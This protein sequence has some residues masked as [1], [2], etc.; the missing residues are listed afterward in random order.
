MGAFLESVLFA[1]GRIA[2][3]T[4]GR[5]SGVA[6]AGAILVLGVMASPAG[7]VTSAPHARPLAACTDSWKTATSGTWATAAD[8]STGVVPTSSDN[9]CITVPG[10]YS[11][12]ISG[13]ASAG[14]LV[15]GASS[16]KE[17]LK[18]LGNASNNG[19]LTLSTATGSQIKTDGVMKLVSK[20]V[21][22]A[23]Y[24]MITG[25]PSVTLEN[26]GTFETSGGLDAEI[27]LRV[28]ITNDSS[29]I[30]KIKGANT[31]EDG[32]SGATNITNNGTFSVASTGSLKISSGSSFTQSGGTLSNSGSISQTSGT[33]TQSGGTDSGN[34]ISLTTST[35][36]DSSGAGDFD[37]FGADTLS[38]TIPSGQTVDVIGDPASDSTA[39]LGTNVTNNGTFELDSQAASSS[40]YAMLNQSSSDFSFTNDG[41][42]ETVGATVQPDYLRADITNGSS[43][44]LTIDGAD[45]AEDGGSGATTFTNDG[46]FSVG[47]AGGITVSSSSS[48]TQSAGTLTNSGSFKV[49]SGTFT[50]SGGTESGNAIS[51]TTSSLVD[52]AG[53]GDFD[54]FGSDNLSGTLPAGQTVEAIGNTTSNAEVTLG[55][56]ITNNGTFELDSQTASGSGYAM[57]YQSSSDFTFT[58]SATGTFETL[59]ATI[60]PDYLRADITNDSGGTFTIDGAETAEDGGNGATTFTNDG[61]FSVGAGGGL[62]VSSS[63]S[64]TQSAGTLANG[65]SIAVSSGTFTQSGGTD[66]GNA[67]SITTSKLVDSAGAGKFNL[68]GSDTLSGTIP[69]GQTVDV[70]GN[71]TSNAE[72]TLGSNVTNNGTFELDSQTVASS[73]YAMLYQSGSDF[74]FTNA[75]TFETLGATVADDYLRADIT[76]DSGGT[77]TIDGA[78]TAEDGASGA[79]SITNGGTLS[80]GDGDNLA[81]SGSSTFTQSSGGTFSPTVDATTGVWGITGG[82]DSVAGT[83]DVNTVGSP[84]VGNTYNVIGTATL[85][86][87]TFSTVVGSYSVTYTT[88][89]V[90][91]KVT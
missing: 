45:T 23:G 63:S 40:G 51:I 3:K 73:G 29:G 77:L 17:S 87:G 20:N 72:T 39:T 24:A 12:K 31:D 44:T 79:T 42:F 19:V 6:G 76:N 53:G 83:L 80:V 90:T 64:F 35:L 59:G 86:S 13:S 38:G 65:G 16:G 85:V 43:G 5:L 21:S 55:S 32:G 75:G 69:S 26:K 30:V 88:T 68:F 47:S 66:S 22:G 34:A 10:T 33:F 27:Y 58:N 81:I 70:I 91:V 78:E 57:L 9:V 62:T 89:A 1:R 14:T 67:I 4:V 28:N 74:T 52:S 60:E 36:A 82:T 46:T 7:A 2:A 56:N 15:L 8:W 11:V 49:S 48:F 37:L 84:T 25:G 18:I 71:T 54:L 50:Q 41:T 61:T